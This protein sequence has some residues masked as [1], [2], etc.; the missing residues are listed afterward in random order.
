MSDARGNDNASHPL[1]RRGIAV[2]VLGRWYALEP[3]P[4]PAGPGL[5]IGWTLTS[6]AG[7]VYRVEDAPAGA[8]CTCPAYLYR[9]GPDDPR[10][11]CKHIRALVA[12]GYVPGPPPAPAPEKGPPRRPI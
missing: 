5:R 6:P 9:Q 3:M 1:P 4:A 7:E 10:G 12:L 11:R 2:D 8:T